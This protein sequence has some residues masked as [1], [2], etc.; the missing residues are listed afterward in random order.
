MG[1]KIKLLFLDVITGEPLFWI[2]AP[3]KALK[4]GRTVNRTNQQ[5]EWLAATN[6]GAQVK[7]REAT[8][9][10]ITGDVAEAMTY[11]KNYPMVF[12][13]D[14]DAFLEAINHVNSKDY[15]VTLLKQIR[16]YLERADLRA[17]RRLA[18]DGKASFSVFT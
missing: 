17:L 15:D 7:Q 3:K 11:D 5:F 1:E 8:M 14:I 10:P 16:Y 12:F 4:E 18:N 2:A 13:R 9:R 6:K